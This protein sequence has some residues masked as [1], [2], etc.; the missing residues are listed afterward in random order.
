V[1]TLGRLLALDE[2]LDGRLAVQLE[3]RGRLAKSAAFLGVTGLKDEPLLQA[4]ARSEYS[5]PV[6]VTA[7]DDM[8]LEHGKLITKLGLTIATI[9][10]RRKPGW[11]PEAWKKETV[12]RWA[13]VMQEQQSGTCRRYSPSGHATWTERRRR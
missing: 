1:T 12:H 6:L 2:G 7:D 9:D 11:P 13:H 3:Q 8:P 4:I 10:G 5:D